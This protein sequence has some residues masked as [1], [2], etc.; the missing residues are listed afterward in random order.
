EVSSDV[1]A[2]KFISTAAIIVGGGTRNPARANVVAAGLPYLVFDYEQA[3]SGQVGGNEGKVVICRGSKIGEVVS[4]KLNLAIVEKIYDADRDATIFCCNG[5]RGDSSWGAVE[6]LCRHWRSLERKYG[7]RG[8]AL[9]LG[10]PDQDSY[11]ETY[12]EPRRLLSIPD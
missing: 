12:V 7:G 9:C 6:Y 3:G 11:M 8:F 2:Q 1:A 10:F 4:Q 5:L